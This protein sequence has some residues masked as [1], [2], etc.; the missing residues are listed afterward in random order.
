MMLY[1]RPVSLCRALAEHGRGDL[2][3]VA[4]SAGYEIE[5]LVAAERVRRLRTTY[6]GLAFFGPAPIL[7]EAVEAQ[8][9]E[10]CDETELTLAAGLSAAALGA[11]W[12]PLARGIIG[13]DYP[14]VR[15]DLRAFR[16]ETSGCEL[17][18]VPAIELDLCL[19]HVPYADARGNAA[20]LS[21][22]CLDG[23]MAAAARQ[24]VVSA[25]RIV[26]PK[27]LQEVAG[28]VDLL[29]F[30]VDAV[31]PSPEGAFPLAC[32]PHYSYSTAD[33]L[34]YLEQHDPTLAA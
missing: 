33:I 15:P 11:P 31:F 21:S 22:P 30:Q 7:R 27:Q 29:S 4:F 32:Y 24:T 1:R 2:E 23:E 25:E 19:I 18:A 8:R 26:T 17:L 16:D 28:Q 5:L 34:E 9:L 14:A 10:L 6:A 3:I 12:I 20:F 13:T